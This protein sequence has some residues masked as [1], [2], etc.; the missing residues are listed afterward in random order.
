MK[1]VNQHAMQRRA[2]DRHRSEAIAPPPLIGV[3]ALEDL[4]IAA[5]D[6]HGPRLE[7][8]LANLVADL[9]LAESGETVRG[10]HQT[11]ALI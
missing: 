2:M 5:G 4:A 3:D 9:E 8:C 1:S 10:Q 11:R 6:D 7:P